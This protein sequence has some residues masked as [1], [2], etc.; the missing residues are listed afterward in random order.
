MKVRL[1]M[2][3]GGNGT[4]F[5]DPLPKQFHQLSGKPV[6]KW[7]ADE[8]SRENIIDS[9]IIVINKKYENIIKSELKNCQFPYCTVEGGNER[10]ISVRNA[11]LKG[12]DE[13]FND[14]DV[15]LIHDATHPIV[16]SEAVKKVI[17]VTKEHGIATVASRVLDT[18]Y[19]TNSE[20]NRV[21]NLL[22]RDYIAVAGSP[23]AFKFS[24]LKKVYLDADEN[25]IK[26]ITCTGALANSLGLDLNVVWMDM[27]NIKLTFKHDLDLLERWFN[28]I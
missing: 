8:Y 10:S 16:D 19:E 9:A 12:I 2:M 6:F 11:L 17:T 23:E 15:I 1:F 25:L 21:K 4:R 13:G 14:D 26:K 27:P 18:A 20:K 7:I 3:L 28:A 22:S 24:L 5:G